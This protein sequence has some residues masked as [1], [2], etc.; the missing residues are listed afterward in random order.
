[1]SGLLLGQPQ[2]LDPI[3]NEQK[4]HAQRAALNS[5]E[6]CL[7]FIQNQKWKHCSNNASSKSNAGDKSKDDGDFFMNTTAED[8]EEGRSE[9][10]NP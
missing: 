9:Q 7:G 6:S 3:L 8:I 10:L 4:E 1:M 2:A 5:M